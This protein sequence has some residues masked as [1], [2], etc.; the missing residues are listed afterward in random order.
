[1]A[2][3]SRCSGCQGR[4]GNVRKCGKEALRL[5]PKFGGDPDYGTAVYLANLTLG[6]V[7]MRDG[8][9]KAAARYLVEASKTPATEELAY[10]MEHLSF[11]LPAWLLKDGER[12]AVV[13]Y[14]ERFAQT[15]IREKKPMLEGARLIRNGKKPS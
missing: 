14:L 8:N 9:R 13:E 1:M 6:M 12:D 3:A 11:K 5:A 15:N 10:T 7:S 4:L 2:R